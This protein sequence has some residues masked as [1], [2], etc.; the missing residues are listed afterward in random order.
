MTGDYVRIMRDGRWIN[1]EIDQ[2]TDAELDDLEQESSRS[3]GI[4][5][6]DRGWA[7]AKSLASWIRDNV[8]DGEG[9]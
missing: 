4:V 6:A 1:V 3:P 9:R 8:K 7:W 5:H 2:L